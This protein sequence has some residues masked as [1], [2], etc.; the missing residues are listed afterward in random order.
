MLKLWIVTSSMIFGP[1]DFGSESGAAGSAP[2]PGP[3][4]YSDSVKRVDQSEETK[5]DC[6][7]NREVLQPS[8]T[9]TDRGPTT[10]RQADTLS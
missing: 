1:I 8:V 2:T 10:F 6:L 9:A 4:E 3:K 5:N 7:P